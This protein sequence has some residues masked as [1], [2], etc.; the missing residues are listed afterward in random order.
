[1]ISGA[2]EYVYG[3]FKIQMY[4]FLNQGKV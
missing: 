1:L 2:D 3:E 4:K